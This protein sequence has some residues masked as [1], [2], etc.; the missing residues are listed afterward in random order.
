MIVSLAQQ[1]PKSISEIIQ[2]KKQKKKKKTCDETRMMHVS[3]IQDTSN[4]S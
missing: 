4:Q 1:L 2:K 3:F